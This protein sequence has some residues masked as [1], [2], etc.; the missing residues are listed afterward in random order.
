M[1]GHEAASGQVNSAFTCSLLLSNAYQFCSSHVRVLQHHRV[2]A[3]DMSTIIVFG[4]FE[5]VVQMKSALLK[6]LSQYQL[7]T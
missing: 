1:A 5:V 3:L 4:V 7:Y 2:H 6:Q